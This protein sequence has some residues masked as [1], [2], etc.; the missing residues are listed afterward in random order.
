MMF[1][2]TKHSLKYYHQSYW[3]SHSSRF[4]VLPFIHREEA[5]VEQRRQNHPQSCHCRL[6][7]VTRLFLFFLG[8]CS[9]YVE[10]YY[11]I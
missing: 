8:S 7:L 3:Y 9:F 1:I 10:Q 6:Y 4:T 11:E 5:K 2:F